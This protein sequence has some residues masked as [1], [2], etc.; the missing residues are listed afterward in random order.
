MVKKSTRNVILFLSLWI[1]LAVI[2]AF[3]DLSISNSLINPKAGWVHFFDVFGEHPAMLIAFI[4]ANIL[5]SLA[6]GEKT[7]KKF[8]MWIINGILMLLT[9]Y[10]MTIMVAVRAFES[11]LSDLQ[12]IITLI[13]TIITVVIIQVLLKRVP[14]ERLNEFRRAALIAIVTVFAF[15]TIANVIKPIWGRA[16]PRDLIGDQSHFF[17]WYIP[18]HFPHGESFPSGHSGNAFSTLLLV[19]FAEKMKKPAVKWALGI[20]IAWGI[21]VVVSRVVIGAHFP[22]D[23]L[24]G[25]F[26]AI[27]LI[28]INSCIFKQKILPNKLDK[29]FDGRDR[30]K[31]LT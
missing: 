27:S 25:G 15:N 10:M 1:I 21:I 17:R 30:I 28:Y 8:F 29:K 23:V 5:F 14:Y 19:L 16:R 12:S 6:R 7:G 26:I 22:S 13:C 24:F 31:S 9:G 11:K 3:T 2:F 20:G 18:Q 4:S